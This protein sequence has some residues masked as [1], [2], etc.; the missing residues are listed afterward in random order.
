M[1]FFEP[2][3][4]FPIGRG[5]V[6]LGIAD[7]NRAPRALIQEETIRTPSAWIINE[8]TFASGP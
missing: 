6:S 4:S 7:Q 2:R 1:S 3:E 5:I 8:C